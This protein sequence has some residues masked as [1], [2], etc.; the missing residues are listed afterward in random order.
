M[1]GLPLYSGVTGASVQ[2]VIAVAGRR[3]RKGLQHAE[4]STLPLLVQ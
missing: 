1:A 3:F 4:V 2:R